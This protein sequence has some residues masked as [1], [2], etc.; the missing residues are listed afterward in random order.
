MNND[1]KPAT[2]GDV[3]EIVTRVVD[4][5]TTKILSSTGDQLQVMNDDIDER[6]DKVDERFDRLERKFDNS[7]DD[8]EV[9]ITKLEKQ[10]V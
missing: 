10:K 3:E 8:H 5:A 9:R 4:G 1:D 6:F 2:R 7:T